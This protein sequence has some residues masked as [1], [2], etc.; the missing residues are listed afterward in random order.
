MDQLETPFKSKFEYSINTNSIN[1][2]INN[3]I[4]NNFNNFNINT[5]NNNNINQNNLKRNLDSSTFNFS[6]KYNNQQQIP[7]LQN[8]WEKLKGCKYIF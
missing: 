8:Y 4:K 3:N 5:L 7:I 1:R 6:P 2:S